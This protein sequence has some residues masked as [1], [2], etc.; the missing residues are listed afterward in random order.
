MALGKVQEAILGIVLIEGVRLINNR[1]L[2]FVDETIDISIATI[3][4]PDIDDPTD[5]VLFQIGSRISG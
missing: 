5:D 4:Q 2:A 3:W 1:S